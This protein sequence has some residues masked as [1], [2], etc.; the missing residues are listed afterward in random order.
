MTNYNEEMKKFERKKKMEELVAT[1][2]VILFYGIL[3]LI[4]VK[5][6]PNPYKW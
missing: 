4:I 2:L 6:M 3:V 5:T 1:F